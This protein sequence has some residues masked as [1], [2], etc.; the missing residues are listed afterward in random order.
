MGSDTILN[1]REPNSVF[2]PFIAGEGIK[3]IQAVTLG[4]TV[5]QFGLR[6]ALTDH[7]FGGFFV[8]RPVLFCFF[9]FRADGFMIID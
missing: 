5:K 4:I 6:H 7:V 3:M 9:T 2:S 8:I 1:I